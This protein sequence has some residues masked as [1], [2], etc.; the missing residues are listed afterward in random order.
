MNLNKHINT[1][2]PTKT[3]ESEAITAYANGS[4]YTAAR[5]RYLL[6]KW[7]ARRFRPFIIVEDPELIE[8]FQMLY[9]RVQIPSAKTI[10]R[11]MKEIYAMAQINVKIL[12]QVCDMFVAFT[13][14]DCLSGLP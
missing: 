8:I 12:L 11:D 6:T 14:T 3:H 4:S 13:Q 7:I 9:A 5:M 2:D 1:C 10:S